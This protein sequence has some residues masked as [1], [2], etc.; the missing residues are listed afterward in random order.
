LKAF[1]AMFFD[2]QGCCKRLSGVGKENMSFHGRPLYQMAHG[3]LY[4]PQP[5]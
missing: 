2:L 5:Q 3:Y 1:E 4:S